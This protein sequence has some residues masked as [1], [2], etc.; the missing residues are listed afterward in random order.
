[1]NGIKVTY[2]NSLACIRVK[3]GE[4][5]SQLIVASIVT[6]ERK[7]NRHRENEYEIFMGEGKIRIR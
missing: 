5:E 7:E 4:R 1:M 3:E 2:V 6:I